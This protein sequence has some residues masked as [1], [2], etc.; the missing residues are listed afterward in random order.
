M[1]LTLVLKRGRERPLEQRHPWIFSGAIASLEQG[2]EVDDIVDV[3]SVDGKFLGRAYVNERSQIVGRVLCFDDVEVDAR[4]FDA[5]IETALALRNDLP[6]ASKTTALR[7]INAEGDGL[8][9]VVVDRYGDHLVMQ[10]LTLGMERRKHQL[11]ELLLA[12]TNAKGVYER[13]DGEVRRKEGLA[14]TTGLLMGAAPPPLVEVEEHGREFLIDVRAGHKTGFYIDQRENRRLIGALARQKTVLNCFCYTGGFGLYAATAGATHVVQLDASEPAL[15]HAVVQAARNRVNDDAVEHA[16]GDAF[17][18][19]RVFREE[20]RTFDVVIM[21][22]PKLAKSRGSVDAALRGYK[23][24]NLL[25]MRLLKPGGYLATF[26]C[27]G[28]IPRDL[29]QKVVFGAAADAQRDMQVLGHL[30]AGGDHPVPLSFPEG[31][32]LKGMLVRAQ[33]RP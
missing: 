1:P 29:F 19:L 31:T 17:H 6:E 3:R 20:K 30:S 14:E 9:G 2:S 32:Y 11:A 5:R 13:S 24:L 12:R 23:D 25:A 16:C 22:P 8:P 4:F 10:V 26:S 15:E 33:P 28:A 21:D 18:V 27:S 7:L